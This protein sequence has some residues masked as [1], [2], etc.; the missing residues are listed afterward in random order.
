MLTQHRLNH[1]LR[2]VCKL[3]PMFRRTAEIPINSQPLHL[4]TAT[5]LFLTDDRNIIFALA[6]HDAGVAADARIEIDGH[7]P[8]VNIAFQ[9]GI[10]VVRMLVN[11]TGVRSMGLKV[12]VFGEIGLGFE[13]IQ[14][15]LANNRTTIHQPMLLSG[16]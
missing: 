3:I 12:H 13:L 7:S 10:R 14:I 8:L 9:R 1:H 11:P 5:N 2:I 16:S 4:A 15:P 6:S